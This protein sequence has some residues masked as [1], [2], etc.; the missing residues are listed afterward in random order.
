M[1]QRKKAVFVC[2]AV[3]I[4]LTLGI[5][6]S[7]TIL[8]HALLVPFIPE[9]ESDFR[10]VVSDRWPE[11][12]TPAK[13][14]G[15]LRI[16]GLADS[17][18][19][20]GGTSNYHYRLEAILRE[21][22][23][24]VEI[25]SLSVPA[26]SL[27]HELVLLQRFGARYEPD[28]IIHGFFVG[29]D[30][31]LGEPV[32]HSYRG[33]R[34]TKM[35]GVSSWYPHNLN[36]FRWVPAWWAV[37][38]ERRRHAAARESG[39]TENLN[40]GDFLEIERVRFG[41]CRLP[42]TDGPAWSGTTEVLDRVQSAIQAMGAAH[43]LLVHPDQFQIETELSDEIFETYA[44]DREAYNLDLPQMFLRAYAES[45][46]IPIV[47]LMPAFRANGSEGGLYL[48]R[49]THYNETGNEL[50]AQILADM[51]EPRIATLL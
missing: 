1:T 23:H 16:V 26:Y 27:E 19:I 12:V 7:E 39:G 13:R 50:V 30:F 48:L 6:T 3:L 25:V 9:S 33:A 5:Y 44:L 2:L 22:G 10:T 35:R 40:A 41:S 28:L 36:V 24:D 34:V 45:R 37:Q 14:P 32:T 29:N 46:G 17:F 20:S 11:S 4:G 18:G 38:S 21:R 51:I 15:S 47:D 31:G 43:L 42:T 49:D 8:R